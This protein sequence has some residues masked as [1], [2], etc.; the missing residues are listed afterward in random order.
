MN[1]D[2]GGCTCHPVWNI[3]DKGGFP[4]GEEIADFINNLYKHR[5]IGTKKEEERFKMIAE[6]NIYDEL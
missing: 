5:K 2:C 4:H 3:I 1:C 6:W